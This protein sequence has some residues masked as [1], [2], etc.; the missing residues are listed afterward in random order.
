MSAQSYVR[1]FGDRTLKGVSSTA[2]R[3]RSNVAQL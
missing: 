3:R 1:W 2:L